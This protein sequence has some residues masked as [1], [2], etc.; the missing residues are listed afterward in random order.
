MQGDQITVSQVKAIKTLRV[1]VDATSGVRL[2]RGFKDL[3]RIPERQF[4][5]YGEPPALKT[6]LLEITGPQ[7]WSENGEI[8]AQQDYPLPCSILALVPDIE[9]GKS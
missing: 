4:E 9:Y 3:K 5:N 1:Q 6:G 8:V 7:G 2:G